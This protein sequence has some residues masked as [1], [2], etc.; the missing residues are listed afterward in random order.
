M[1][2]QKFTVGISG[3]ATG[4]TAKTLLQLTAAPN[5]RV[6]LRGFSLSFAGI[7]NT[8]P[9]V[10]LEIVRQTTAGTMSSATPVRK[11]GL[12]SETI[13]TT[14]THAASAEPT[15]TDVVAR[16][17]VHPQTGLVVRFLADS[18]EEIILPGGTR[19]GFRLTTGTTQ[20]ATLQADFEE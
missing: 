5:V 4:A 17:L 6:A 10:L 9:P 3:V 12:G 19:L 18:D 15:T 14:A 7:V 2:R 20:N 11:D 16:Y 8:D 1:A 13:Q